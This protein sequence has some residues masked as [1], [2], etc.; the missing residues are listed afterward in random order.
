LI[1]YDA[2]NALIV[3]GSEDAI[4]EVM[5]ILQLIDVPPKQIQIETRYVTL[6]TNKANDLGISWAVSNGELATSSQSS[7]AGTH[8]LRY[9]V[10]NF[11]ATIE[12]LIRESKGKVINAPTVVIQNG[13]IGAIGVFQDRPFFIPNI[14]TNQFGIREVQ[15]EVQSFQA[16]T[17]LFV[18]ARITGVPPNE[19]ITFTLM[20]Q[21][22]DFAG[23]VVSPDGQ[24]LPIQIQQT[25]QTTLRVKDGETI[26]MGGL[27]R[28]DNVESEEKVPLLGDLPWL[29]P[30]L[31]RNRT[32]SNQTSELLIFVTPTII[33]DPETEAVAEQAR[34]RVA[35]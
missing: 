6:T 12:A 23:E 8:A 5:E 7:V 30:L 2:L 1:G 33:R 19:S 21:V 3:R 20:P 32:H 15:Y 34:P 11:T 10:G 35:P 28:K 14:S 17:F 18:L 24:R 16:G 22:S 29:G 26:A 9:A 27:M 4:Q 13:Q 31:F 25:I